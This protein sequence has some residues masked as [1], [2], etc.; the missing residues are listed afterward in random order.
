MNKKIMAGILAMATLAQGAAFAEEGIMLISENPISAEEKVSTYEKAHLIG[1]LEKREDG[2]FVKDAGEYPEVQLNTDE[3]T[4]FVGDLGNPV[5][6]EEIADGTQVSIIA[7]NA[8]TRS[9]PAQTYAYIVMAADENGGFPIYAEVSDVTNEDGTYSAFSKDGE[10]KIVFNDDTQVVPFATKN[11]VKSVD[12]QAGSRILVSSE[13]MTMS[14][15]A[16]V[17]AEKI[18]LLPEV[19]ETEENQDENLDKIPDAI[20]LNGK[21][22]DTAEIKEK[23]FEQDGVY[24]LPL[25][26]ICEA[27]GLEVEWDDA[28]KAVTVGTVQMGVTLNIGVNKYTKAKMMAAELSSAPILVN[29]TTFVPMDFFTDILEAEANIENG[30][31]NVN[32]K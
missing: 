30:E 6:I 25:R 2:I 27:A 5:S 15:P 21:S 16:V 22:F 12:I 20:I 9:L 1:T 10:Y 26:A 23:M 8:M 31:I 18:V 28:K 14:I 32:L 11:I 13:L 17:P 4:L 29:D 3:N 24:F 7:S 19:F